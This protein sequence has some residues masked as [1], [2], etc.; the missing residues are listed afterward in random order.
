MS[1]LP[2]LTQIQE[3]RDRVVEICQLATEYVI[4]TCKDYK[5]QEFKD[6]EFSVPALI[7]AGQDLIL[8]I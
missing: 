7:R 1:I 5:N 8:Y 3:Q 4:T 6:R 2:S